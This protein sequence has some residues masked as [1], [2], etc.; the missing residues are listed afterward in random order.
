MRQ[1]TAR[2]AREARLYRVSSDD[3]STRPDAMKEELGCDVTPELPLII[4]RVA[5]KSGYGG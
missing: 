3:T 4:V 5:T 2:D 1:V